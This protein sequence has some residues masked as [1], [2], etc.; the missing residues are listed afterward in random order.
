V[1]IVGDWNG[2]GNDK[3]GVV[4]YG[5]GVRRPLWLLRN[6]S[7]FVGADVLFDYG[8]ISDTY[9]FTGD[10]NGDGT[11]TPGVLRTGVEHGEAMDYLFRNTNT[12]GTADSGFR[13]YNGESLGTPIVD[14]WDGDGDDDP[15]GIKSYGLPGGLYWSLS[16]KHLAADARR[17]VY[18]LSTDLPVIW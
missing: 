18:G 4:R 13:V 6:N 5:I 11:D 3:P 8:L 15:G 2:N 1:P 9:P 10:W 16:T 17:F 7:N 12:S 14:D